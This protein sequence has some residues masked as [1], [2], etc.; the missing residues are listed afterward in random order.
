MIE[1]PGSSSTY[2]QNFHDSIRN[3]SKR[4]VWL[5]REK[6]FQGLN[7]IAWDQFKTKVKDSNYLTVNSE[8]R[9]WEQLIGLLNEVRGYNYLK[10]LDCVD[11]H[12]LPNESN[13]TP[14]LEGKFAEE[15]ILCEVKTLNISDEESER[16]NG[17]VAGEVL[18]FLPEGFMDKLGKA[19]DKAH[20]Q[21]F[22]FKPNA[23]RIVYI[24]INFDDFLGESKQD[25]YKQIDQYLSNKENFPDIEIVFHIEQGCFHSSI[26]MENATV[27]NEG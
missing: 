3:E 10:N 23:R 24:N 12:F 7:Q 18:N 8:L 15:I 22:S 2:F 6:E 26:S 13:E 19:I 25:Y 27:I 20:N 5:R 16:R 1:E 14:D 9:G 21:C 17:L 4:R 11:I